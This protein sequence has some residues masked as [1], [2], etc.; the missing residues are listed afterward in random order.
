VAREAGGRFPPESGEHF[1]FLNKFE[2]VTYKYVII[3]SKLGQ[4]FVSLG[5]IFIPGPPLP[6]DYCEIFFFKLFNWKI[7]TIE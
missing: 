2:P 7:H 6:I 1:A 4:I 3:S 5:L